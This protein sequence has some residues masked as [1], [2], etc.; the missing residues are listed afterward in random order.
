MELLRQCLPQ[1]RY[2]RYYLKGKELETYLKTV[3][4]SIVKCIAQISLNLLYSH[5]NGININKSQ[6]KKLKP[7]K[8]SMK[9]LV[10]LKSVKKQKKLLKK[11]F[12]YA[13]L[14]VMLPIVGEM[15]IDG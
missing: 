6:I 11:P 12:V 3:S 13:L 4:N 8:K 7:F 9:E 14:S 10:T 1:L 15:D 5:K 2:I